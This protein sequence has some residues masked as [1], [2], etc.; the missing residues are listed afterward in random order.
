MRFVSLLLASS[1]SLLIV[2]G[3]ALPNGSSTLESTGPEY[4]S[5]ETIE[6]LTR[7]SPFARA[8][9][10]PDQFKT[11]DCKYCQLDGIK[12]FVYRVAIIKPVLKSFIGVHEGWKRI[13]LAFR[14]TADIGG[15]LEDGKFFKRPLYGEESEKN[16]LHGNEGDNYDELKSIEVHDGFL[17]TYMQGRGEIIDILK[18]YVRERPDYQ[19]ELAGHS[20]GGALATICAYDIGRE[21]PDRKIVLTTYGSPRVGNVAF[22]TIFDSQH[23]PCHV[24][25]CALQ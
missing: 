5:K 17:E 10:F 14:G 20:L 13:I 15:V 9:Y 7:Y 12:D 21:F 25:F 18:T 4:A 1:F 11:W 8:A 16:K 19:I 6:Q 24:S 23:Q 22:C 3:T 2:P